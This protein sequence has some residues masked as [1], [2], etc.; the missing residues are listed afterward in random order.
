MF[1]IATLEI[2]ELNEKQKAN[3]LQNQYQLV[4]SQNKQLEQRN[5]ELEEKFDLVTKLNIELQNTERELRDELVT[6]IPQNQFNE[7]NNNLKEVSE[8]EIKL[9]IEN[10]KLREIADVAQNQVNDLEQRKEL[11]IHELE[12]LRHQV[13][14]LQSMTDEKAL[15]GRL[16][17]Q[18]ISLQNKDLTSYQKIKS[19]QKQIGKLESSL[20]K[21]GNKSENMEQLTIK[22]R[23]QY[24]VKLRSLQKII[25]DLRRQYSGSIPLLKQEKFSYSLVEINMEKQKISGLLHETESKLKVMEIEKEEMGIKKA[26]VDEILKT[27]RHGSGTRQILEW[28]SKLEDLRLKE[29][30]ARRNAEQ[31]EKE[32][33]HLKESSKTIITRNEQL[34]EELIRMESLM[35]QRQLEW[36]THEVELEKI[37][38]Q[39]LRLE[40]GD[41][42][43][44]ESQNVPSSDAPL[45]QQLEAALTRNKHLSQQLN[46]MKKKLQ[47]SRTGFE[48]LT[49]KNR[50]LESQNLSKD[51]MINDLR[52]EIP[53]SVDR[54]IAINSVIG[55]PGIPSACVPQTNNSATLFVAQGTIDSLR[56]RLK[57]KEETIK[58]YEELLQQAN[59]EHD[60]SVKRKQ[61]EIIELN[62]RMRE[63]QSAYNELRSSRMLEDFTS[64]E[65]VNKYV[66]RTQ[67]LED[68]V[69]ELLDSLGNVTTQLSASKA[70]KEKLQKM[71]DFKNNEIN[72]IKE[73][74]N[75]ENS[76]AYYEKQKEIDK[77]TSEIR[78]YQQENIILKED[79]EQLKEAQSKAPS[80][81]MKSLVERLKTDLAEKEKKQKAMSRVIA[82]LKNEMIAI[83]GE[84][85]KNEDA[86]RPGHLQLIV[87]K[88]TRSYQSKIDEQIQLIDKLKRQLKMSKESEAKSTAEASRLRDQVEKKSSLILKL[89]E[90][91]MSN[92]RTVSR[93]TVKTEQD[94]IEKEELRSQLQA[95]EEKLK[96]M[97]HAEKPFEDDKELKVIKNAEEVARWD[98]KKKWQKKVE[99]LKK[100]LKDADEEVSKISKQ[101]DTLRETVSRL[102]REKFQLDL[103]WKNHL[104]VGT[105]KSSVTDT[106]IQALQLENSQLKERISELE[107]KDVMDQNPGT[108]TLKLRIKFL[109]ERIEQQ[110]KKIALLEIAKKGGID[111]LMK[112]IE[113]LRKKEQSS[114]KQKGKLE[115]TNLDMKLKLET[116]QHNLVLLKEE[117]EELTKVVQALRMASTDADLVH[118]L[119]KSTEQINEILA[120][121]AGYG[122]IVKI[123]KS[124]KKLPVSDEKNVRRLSEEVESL[125][126]NLEKLRE[127]NSTLLETLE[128]KERKIAELNLVI[129]ELEQ[130]VNTGII[131][132]QSFFN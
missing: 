92:S 90:E 129:R 60:E 22:V 116:T 50:E 115:D 91:K 86:H 34:E 29:L 112:E 39:N 107:H 51:R 113:N 100:K 69:Q 97:N 67:E 84:K 7:L 21:A 43:F 82:D 17:Q 65:T 16:H 131:S 20:L 85:V 37:D 62:A 77:L 111:A 25:Q 54:A 14:D 128:I 4:Q 45:S 56:E 101:N 3:H 52:L 23:S 132:S 31:W 61:D 72:I 38:I 47:D 122:R 103:K 102:D 108:E 130:S 87:D 12:S 46:S 93:Q 13:L 66:T 26:G 42:T 70:E 30:H 110:E 5:S 1:K 6:S 53:A 71:L 125:T 40:I 99:E 55:Q 114:D 109:Q 58:K 96:I 120:N 28:H 10:E 124:P 105:A 88:E 32:L 123:N 117:C 36:E 121:T 89:R 68:E 79:I 75:A 59:T 80:V 73:G 18:I 83:A 9:K 106:R 11:H 2:R 24:N 126:G 48:E 127:E 27:L 95:L 44:G 57:L 119:E 8:S 76:T 104:K 49:K 35:E 63:Q 19:L 64:S 74:N 81:I 15:I 118:R 41:N 78:N 98:E 94:D 33:F